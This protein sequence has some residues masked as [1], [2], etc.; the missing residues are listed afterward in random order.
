MA[1]ATIKK[2]YFF[3]HNPVHIH[4]SN[5]CS[6]YVGV[7]HKHKFVEVVYIISGRAKHIIDSKEYYVKKGDVSVINCDEAHAFIEDKEYG[8]KFLAYDLMFTPDFLD[9]SCLSSDDFSLLS[10]SF[11]FFSMFPDEKGFKERFNF[12]PNCSYELGLVFEKIYREYKGCRTGYINLIRLYTAE[13][14]IRLL[15]KIQTVDENRLSDT[16]RN[17]V[18]EIT[19]YLE[20]NYNMKI[21][22]DEIASRMF[23]SQNYLSKIFKQETG[24]SIHEFLTD[25]RIKQACK[26]LSSTSDNIADIATECGF[27]DMK[28]FYCIFKKYMGETPKRYRDNAKKDR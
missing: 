12:I 16:Q 22:I 14:I 25:I 19:Q 26:K 23:F 4:L 3:K 20:Q 13:I 28:S 2:D 21:K 5:E 15:R 7:L 8:E 11:L 6:E 10:S 17:T 27:S 24:L 18:L 9:N 1:V